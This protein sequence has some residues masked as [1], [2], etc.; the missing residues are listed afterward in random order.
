MTQSSESDDR[1]RAIQHLFP[2]L[3]DAEQSAL[4]HALDQHQMI[5]YGT[6]HLTRG[7][8]GD[9]RVTNSSVYG[10]VI[11]VNTGVVFWL[12]QTTETA[13][14]P[15]PVGLPRTRHPIGYMAIHQALHATWAEVCQT[16]TPT[17]DRE[18]IRVFKGHIT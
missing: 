18:T 6:Q 3:S 16:K 12:G 17:W 13:S 11:G 1:I 10:P 9:V 15:R 14:R 2:T 8:T 5:P 7:P 4:L